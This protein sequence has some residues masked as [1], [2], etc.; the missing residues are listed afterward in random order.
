MAVITVQFIDGDAASQ[1]DA[2]LVEPT[3]FILRAE[4]DR[5]EMGCNFHQAI[6]GHDPPVPVTSSSPAGQGRKPA[7]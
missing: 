7:I 2:M 5:P 6:S 1:R 3:P 4:A